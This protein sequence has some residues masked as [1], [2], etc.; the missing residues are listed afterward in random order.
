MPHRAGESAGIHP[1]KMLENQKVEK[2]AENTCVFSKGKTIRRVVGRTRSVWGQQGNGELG[3][4]DPRPQRRACGERSGTIADPDARMAG[5]ARTGRSVYGLEGAGAGGLCLADGAEPV[6]GLVAQVEEGSGKVAVFQ[7]SQHGVFCGFDA[8]R[9]EGYGAS[10]QDDGAAGHGTGA[11]IEAAGPARGPAL[12]VGA[13]YRQEFG[14]AEFGFDMAR[15][16]AEVAA[17]AQE[18]EQASAGRLERNGQFGGDGAVGGGIRQK[19]FERDAGVEAEEPAETFGKAA[20][21]LESG[22]VGGDAVVGQIFLQ[23]AFPGGNLFFA[24]GQRVVAEGIVEGGGEVREAGTEAEA[25]QKGAGPEGAVGPEFFRTGRSAEGGGWRAFF[26]ETLTAAEF[27]EEMASG[28]GGEESGESD[29]RDGKGGRDG[30]DAVVGK[31]GDDFTGGH[32][33]QCGAFQ[34]GLEDI[35]AGESDGKWRECQ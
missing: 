16:G 31:M 20:V 34:N 25:D 22:V 5:R 17:V 11:G 4:R 23:A 28:F 18:P 6:Q 26:A 10:V 27:A 2:Q 1:G 29:R 33:G 3:P 24:T 13:S 15:E 14:N 9:G 30:N 21:A 35:H 32:A 7:K 19:P 8:G 12:A